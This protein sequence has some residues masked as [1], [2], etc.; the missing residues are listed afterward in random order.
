MFN[1]ELQKIGLLVRT[2]HDLNNFLLVLPPGLELQEYSDLFSELSVRVG[3]WIKASKKEEGIIA[4]FAGI[5]IDTESI[6][7][8][9]P[10][11][12]LLKGQHL[13]QNPI[14]RRSA[15]LLEL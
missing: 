10:P 11:K 5:E 13:V 1:H 6:V 14:A 7:I 2:I 8:R 9:L 15:K 3:L 12:K 4:S